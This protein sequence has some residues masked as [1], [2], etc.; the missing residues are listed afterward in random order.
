MLYS[1]SGLQ[2]IKKAFKIALKKS[3]KPQKMNCDI[4]REHYASNPKPI[5]PLKRYGW[6]KN[7]SDSVH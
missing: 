6:I 1:Q 7:P 5:I 4:A 2:R 3:A